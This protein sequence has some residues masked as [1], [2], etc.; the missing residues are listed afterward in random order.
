MDTIGNNLANVNTTAYK[1]YDYEFSTLFCSTLSSG[2][3]AD[4]STG[5]DSVNPTQ[6]GY[7]AQTGSSSQNFEQGSFDITGNPLDMALEGDGFF[8]LKQG[9]SEV[10][11]RSGDFYIGD[12]YALLAADGLYVQGVMA[13]NGV[14]PAEASTEDIY[15]PIGSTSEAHQTTEVAFSG[16]LDATDEIAT[17]T[18]LISG[19]SVT[20]DA[21]DYLG[22]T[23]SDSSWTA[24]N[25]TTG[26]AE[27]I[28]G[29][30]VQTSAA[31]A[32]INPA[33]DPLDPT[34]SE[35]IASNIDT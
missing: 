26:S 1:G 13:N 33:Y 8:V 25:S 32:V 2:A 5:R 15:I 22:E 6:I 23:T 35:Y 30:T 19:G 17:V 29:G 10:Y 18:K 4:S 9:N 34:S 11:T 3:S 7:G 27:Y 20:T 28:N 14:I 16:N 12:D 21:T 24:L 31:Y